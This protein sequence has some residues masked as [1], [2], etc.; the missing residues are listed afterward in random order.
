MDGQVLDGIV[1]LMLCEGAG[2]ALLYRLRG[3]GVKP[4][5]LL[6]SLASGMCL[7]LAM[8]AALGGAWWPYVSSWLLAA[9]LFHLVDLR[10]QWR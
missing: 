2:L 6:P 4:G 8:R 5:A 9:L 7:L 10:R 1:I 3:R